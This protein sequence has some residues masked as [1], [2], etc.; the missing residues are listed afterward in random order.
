MKM[1]FDMKF[2]KMNAC[3]ENITSA[4]LEF[5][6]SILSVLFFILVHGF[7][8]V[9]DVGAFLLLD[10]VWQKKMLTFPYKKVEAKNWYITQGLLRIT[11]SLS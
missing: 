8:I 11:R 5:D 10:L 4:Y 1:G 6:W 9:E 2:K 7:V 3:T